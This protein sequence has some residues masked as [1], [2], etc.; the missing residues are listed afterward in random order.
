[1]PGFLLHKDAQVLCQHG[2]QAHPQAHSS[3]V[4]VSG[5]PI[6]TQ[7]AYTIDGCTFPSP[8]AANGPC[9]TATW[10][11]VASRVFSEGQPV[12]LS[13]EGTLCVPTGTPLR[14]ASTQTRVQ[15]A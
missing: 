11:I 10:V 6:L 3:R 1:M 13:G 15:G 9:A 2:A 8:N 7:T 14:A 5:K 4:L 12:L